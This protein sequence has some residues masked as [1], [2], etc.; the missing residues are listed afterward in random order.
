MK[1]LSAG[2]QAHLDEGTTTLAWCWR[3]MRADGVDLRL[4]RSRPDAELRR[5]RLRARERADGFRGPLGLGPVGRCAGRRGRA[6]LRPDHRD[7]HP[8][9]PLG[10]CRGRGLAGELDDDAPARAD[11]ARRH[12]PDPARAAGLR[13]RGPVARPCPRPDGRADL[14][15]DLRCRARR[16]AL[17]GR[18]GRPD[19][20][21]YWRRHRSSARPGLHRLGARRLHLRLVHLRH[22]GLDER[23]EC[24]ATH[25]GAGP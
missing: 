19:L 20:Q 9:R 14:P 10:Q 22:A 3:I 12:R 5:D 15:G 18:S 25:R 23:R 1:S 4:H 17:R 7:R 8:R 13:R 11:A 16:C 24:R 6:D 2:L 21:G